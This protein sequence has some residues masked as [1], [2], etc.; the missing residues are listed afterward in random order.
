MCVL[1]VNCSVEMVFRAGS[2]SSLS[3]RRTCSGKSELW[4]QRTTFVCL[5]S[6]VGHH[7]RSLQCWYVAQNLKDHLCEIVDGPNASPSPFVTAVSSCAPFISDP[8]HRFCWKSTSRGGS[9]S[10]W[11]HQHVSL[12]G[13][14]DAVQASHMV[15][16]NR[17][18]ASPHSSQKQKHFLQ[19]LTEFPLCRCL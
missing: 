10:P 5:R 12:L 14:L 17:R 9:F 3:S 19:D 2:F 13:M 15:S 11:I 18:T 8:S 7:V 6:C 1:F 4:Q 16:N